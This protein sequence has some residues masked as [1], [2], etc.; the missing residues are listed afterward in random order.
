MRI[1]PIILNG[2]G[3][4]LAARRAS[5]VPSLSDKNGTIGRALTGLPEPRGSDLESKL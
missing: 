3:L 2:P 5:W 4:P 1:G